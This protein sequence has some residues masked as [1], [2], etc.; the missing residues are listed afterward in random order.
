[1]TLI[2]RKPLNIVPSETSSRHDF[3]FIIGRWRIH[4]RKLRERLKG[5]NDWFEFEGTGEAFKILN[6]WGNIKRYCVELDGVPF[7]GIA[8]RVFNPTT[9]LWTIYWM[10]TKTFALDTP[11]VG[12]FEGKVGRFY[13][14]D[15]HEG[16]DIII[17]YTYDAT[18]SESGL[19]LWS[20]AFSPDEGAT[21]ETNWVMSGYREE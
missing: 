3:D 2:M 7:E 15:A 1:V 17:R 11:V 19:A 14:Q 13:S 4:H 20:Q 9:R 21:W 12:S 6:D 10:D 16:V 8:L 18:H 5:S